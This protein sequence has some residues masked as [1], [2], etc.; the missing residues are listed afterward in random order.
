MTFILKKGMMLRMFTYLYDLEIVDEDAF[1]TWKEAINED[2]PGKGKALFQ[3]RKLPLTPF[4]FWVS[5][6]A[7]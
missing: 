7:N 1:M 6:G 3:V 4:S 2:Y 5:L